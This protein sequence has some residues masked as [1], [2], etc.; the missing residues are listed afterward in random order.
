MCKLNAA[1]L[2][3]FGTPALCGGAGEAVSMVLANELKKDG[4]KNC[5]LS[6]EDANK[7][8]FDGL[9]GNQSV[10]DRWL[11]V[12]GIT[13]VTPITEDDIT[14]TSDPRITRTLSKGKR[15]YTISIVTDEPNQLAKKFA[16]NKCQDSILYFITDCGNLVGMDSNGDLCGRKVARLSTTVINS[17]VQGG[18]AGE[19]LVTIEFKSTELDTKVAYIGTESDE[20][21][22]ERKGLLDVELSNGVATVNDFTFDLKTCYG[23]LNDEIPATGLAADLEIYNVTDDA[24][25]AITG[26]IAED[27]DGTYKAT[28]AGVETVGKNLVPRGTS[29]ETVKSIYDIKR[30]DDV[31]T[32]IA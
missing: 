32:A 13:K 1:N 10:V 2:S 29:S 25:V 23:E 22:T 9:F 18:T 7:A 20:D 16:D 14:D 19:V 15:G 17:S 3:N 24:V 31:V 5:V 28:F 11:T 6:T 26:A 8:L 12:Q 30:I 4:E 21:L 27:P